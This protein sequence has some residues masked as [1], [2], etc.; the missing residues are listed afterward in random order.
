M[1]LQRRCVSLLLLL[2]S[3]SLAG[4]TSGKPPAAPTGLLDKS[5][6]LITMA[7]LDALNKGFADRYMTLVVNAAEN[8]ERDNP[9][10]EQRRMAHLFKLVSVTSV[11]DIVTNADPYT[12]LLDLILMV[13]L[14]S[15]IWIDDARADDVFKDR[16]DELVHRLRRARIEIW[17]LAARVLTQEQLEVL[18]RLIWDWKHDNPDAFL[19]GFVRFSEFA[20]SRGK[21]IIADVPKGT[22]FLA[23]VDEATRAVDDVRLLA[24]RA[25][26]L[27][28]RLPFLLN[29]QMEAGVNDLLSKPEVQRQM[30]AVTNIGHAAMQMA[31]QGDRL[32]AQVAEERAAIF[33]EIDRRQKDL[34]STISQSSELVKSM[35]QL[36]VVVNEITTN[37]KATVDSTDHILGRYEKNLPEHPTSKPADTTAT[38]A[39]VPAPATRP[40]ALVTVPTPDITAAPSTQ[41]KAGKPFDLE[42]YHR[43]AVDL[44]TTVRELN[45]LMN[46]TDK[47]VASSAW[48]A[49]LDEVN[50]ATEQRVKQATQN[51][52]DIVDLIFQRTIAGAF[53]ILCLLAIYRVF[54]LWMTR[55]AF[56]GRPWRSPERATSS[57]EEQP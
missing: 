29:W 15:Q 13:T 42:E 6:K 30:N 14:Q 56:G 31:A 37:L 54:M 4:C 44:A 17:E 22:G 27:S 20:S 23:P 3:L 52:R 16:A 50:Q 47:L 28:K 8:L 45:T 46:S 32:P 41:P 34:S 9:D 26:Y 39:P 40:L 18:D 19:V 7:Q 1:C 24:E 55:R 5:G 21:S 25:F 12:D 48:T 43:M 33:K 51:S 57:R 36:A 11:Y 38:T 49:R 35:Q 10:L 53:I 2:F